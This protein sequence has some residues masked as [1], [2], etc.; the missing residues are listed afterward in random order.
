MTLRA[1]VGRRSP[2]ASRGKTG[3]FSAVE[4]KPLMRPDAVG[5]NVPQAQSGPS[6]PTVSIVVPTYNE[7]RN[8]PHVFSRL[9]DDV[10]EVILVDGRS[11]DATIEV[12]RALRPGVRIVRQNR[13]GKGNA[14][15]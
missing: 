7:A 2:V 1:V 13:R 12:A 6:G 10:H 14:L 4:G 5:L 3:P 9:P 11:V 15:A 8:L